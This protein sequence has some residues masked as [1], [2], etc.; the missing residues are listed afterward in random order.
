MTTSLPTS[1]KLYEAGV[2]SSHQEYTYDIDQDTRYP[3]YST[4]ELLDILPSCLIENNRRYWLNIEKIKTNYL[5]GYLEEYS[6]DNYIEKSEQSDQILC[7]ALAECL[8]WLK[9]NYPESL[10]V[11]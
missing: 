6:K 4:D 11:K 2:I 8:L 7:E 9:Q 10:E 1:K 3:S 5:V